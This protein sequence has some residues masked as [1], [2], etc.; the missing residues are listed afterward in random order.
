MT[1]RTLPSSV[2]QAHHQ[3][4]QDL[5]PLATWLQSWGS[6]QT[7]LSPLGRACHLLSRA[8]IMKLIYQVYWYNDE[9]QID[10]QSCLDEQGNELV[11]NNPAISRAHWILYHESQSEEYYGHYALSVPEKRL[12][13]LGDAQIPEDEADDEL[14]EE[15]EE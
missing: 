14:F 5:A 12:V 4:K 13:R 7:D 15:A 1:L 2:L 6:P 10:V 8:G 3:Q 11:P 9:D